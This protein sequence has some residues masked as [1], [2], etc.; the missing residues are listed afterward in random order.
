MGITDELEIISAAL[1]S[2]SV[3]ASLEEL[4]QSLPIPIEKRTLPIPLRREG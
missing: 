1:K 4:H 3:G 2:F